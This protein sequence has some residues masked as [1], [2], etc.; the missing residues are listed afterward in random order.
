MKSRSQWIALAVWVTG[1]LL[2]ALGYSAWGWGGVAL[3]VGAVVFW[4][5]LHFT[6]SLAVLKRAAGRP[7]GHVDSAVMLHSRL[8]AGQ[9][10][11][12]V[13]GLTRSLGQL[14]GEANAQPERYRW[15]DGGGSHVDCEFSDGRLTHFELHRPAQDTEAALDSMKTAPKPD[16]LSKIGQ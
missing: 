7:I 16:S 13:V 3:T 2:V 9:K 11:L 14:L 15:Q 10:L 1:A 8:H 4:L 6:R 5:L 12:H